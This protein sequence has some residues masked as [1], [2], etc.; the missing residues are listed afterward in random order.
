MESLLPSSRPK[1]T[2]LLYPCSS[3]KPKPLAFLVNT[4]IY[5]G[6]GFNRDYGFVPVHFDF[7][8]VKSIVATSA[9][10]L[11]ALPS[12]ILVFGHFLATIFFPRREN[13]RFD[14]HPDIFDLYLT[15]YKWSVITIERIFDFQYVANKTRWRSAIRSIILVDLISL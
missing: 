10:C 14:Y 2:A 6:Y 11:K 3:K 9:S 1:L 13:V 12:R 8:Q 15:V 7:I 4:R 5:I